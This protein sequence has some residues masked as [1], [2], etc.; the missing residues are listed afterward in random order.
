M[1]TFIPPA[2]TTLTLT[3]NT[4]YWIV[5]KGTGDGWFKAALGENAVAIPGWKLA[6]NY[7][8]RP[9]Y[10]Y[11][12]H[13][14]QTINTE[15][16]IFKVPGHMSVRINRQNNAATGQPTISGTPQTQQ[17]LTVSTAGIQDVDGLPAT[18]NY[19]WMRYSADGTTFESNIGTDSNEY[20]L[21]LA[22]EGK[23]IRVRI[24]SFIDAATNDEGPFL[25]DLYPSDNT[26]IAPLIYTMVSNVDKTVDTPRAVTFSSEPRSQSFT[27]SSETGSYILTSATILS[28]DSEGDEFTVKICEVQSDVPTTSCND[29]DTPTSFT[30]GPLEFT[31]P[32]NRTIT[33]FKATSYALVFSAAAGTMVTIPA[34]DV[35]VEDPITLPAGSYGTSP[36]SFPTTNGRTATTTFPTSSPSRPAKRNQPSLGQTHNP[37]E[38]I[39]RS[40]TC[41][42]HRQ[43]YCSRRIVQPFLIPVE[44]PLQQRDDLRSQHWHQLQP[45][46]AHD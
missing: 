13:G 10:S 17:T 15:T 20:R 32:S 40:S 33:L 14:T 23:R 39:S 19:Q 36:N 18:F 27:T 1:Y 4:H 37:R 44:T 41:R 34:T 42:K 11:D 12:E 25:S 3:A 26:V 21:A 29:L 28:V 43:H 9:K 8:F 24:N 22:D 35:D 6:D 31:S 46:H 2:N 7:E 30:A 38:S 5:V 45:V 16:K